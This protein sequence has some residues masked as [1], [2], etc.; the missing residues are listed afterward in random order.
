MYLFNIIHKYII[1]ERSTS[2]LVNLTVEIFTFSYTNR[3]DIIAFAHLKLSTKGLEFFFVSSTFFSTN[4]LLDQRKWPRC[5]KRSYACCNENASAFMQLIK[6]RKWLNEH[7]HYIRD[8]M[9]TYE[10][11]SDRSRNRDNFALYSSGDFKIT[12]FSCSDLV[13]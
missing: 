7:S 4:T 11:H 6:Y 13:C 12:Y 9:W 2:N 10:G 5:R 3:A 1:N 8:C